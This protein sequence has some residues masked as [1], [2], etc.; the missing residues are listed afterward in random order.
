MTKMIAHLM[1]RRAEKYDNI[2][3]VESFTQQRKASR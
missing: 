2:T 1:Q 3:R